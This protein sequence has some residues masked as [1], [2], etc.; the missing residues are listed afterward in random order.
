MK[1]DKHKTSEN[2][3]FHRKEHPPDVQGHVIHDVQETYNIQCVN[4]TLCANGT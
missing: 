4:K 1:K 2:S 3:L